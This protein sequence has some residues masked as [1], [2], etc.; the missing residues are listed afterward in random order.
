MS[1]I[2]AARSQMAISLVFHIFFA[3]IGVALPPMMVIAEALWLRT[4]G[5]RRYSRLA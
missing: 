2:F 5:S 1:D 4:H 3:A